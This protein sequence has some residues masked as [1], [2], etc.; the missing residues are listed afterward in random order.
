M[1]WSV[2][3]V[4]SL[5]A[6]AAFDVLPEQGLSVSLGAR[7]DGIPTRDLIGGGDDDTI[8]RTS[9]IIFVDPGLS[10]AQGKNSFTLSV[11]WR[12]KV[13]RTMSIPEQNGV[14]LNAGGFAKYLVF[15]SYSRRL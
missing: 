15:A 3:D 14:G 8:K 13:K 5:R 6:G 4:Y 10:F 7:I 12:V 11:P 2:P 1:R 9:R